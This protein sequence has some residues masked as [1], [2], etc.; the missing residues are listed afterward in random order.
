MKHLNRIFY[1]YTE[2]SIAVLMAIAGLCELVCGLVVPDIQFIAF[3]A[4]VAF[5]A[6]AVRNVLY[7]RRCETRGFL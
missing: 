1:I 4:S 2:A 6:I 7:I 5:L 3:P